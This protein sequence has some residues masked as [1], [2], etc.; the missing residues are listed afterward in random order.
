MDELNLPDFGGKVIV[1][2]VRDSD[3]SYG[4]VVMNYAAFKKYGNRLF[5]EGRVP[6]IDD[7]SYRWVSKLQTAAAWDDVTSYLVFDSI[8]EYMHRLKQYKT[9]FMERIKRVFTG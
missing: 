2:Y 1:L 3:T 7:D 4:S 5:V 8:E 9:P 6:Q